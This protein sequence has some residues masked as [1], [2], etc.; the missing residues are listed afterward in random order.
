MKYRDVVERAIANAANR[1]VKHVRKITG[2]FIDAFPAGHNLNDDVDPAEAAR[3]LAA[4]RQ[5]DQVKVI[6]QWL[7]QGYVEAVSGGLPP[8][9]RHKN[10]R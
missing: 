4:F 1:K 6:R 3:L 7:K 10:S 8:G 5:P 2:V 9:L